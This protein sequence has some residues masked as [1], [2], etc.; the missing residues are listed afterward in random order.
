MA[1]S[2]FSILSD[3]LGAKYVLVGV[4]VQGNAYCIIL[5]R[6]CMDSNAAYI[7]KQGVERTTAAHIRQQ[8]TLQSAS[9]PVSVKHL[10]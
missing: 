3:L 5:R 1:L 7:E 10:L 6:A 9:P 2:L 4:Y 8:Q